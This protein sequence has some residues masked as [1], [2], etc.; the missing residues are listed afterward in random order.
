MHEIHSIAQ[1]LRFGHACAVQHGSIAGAE[2]ATLVDALL[3]VVVEIQM[4]LA[5]VQI[6]YDDIMSAFS[7]Q[8]AALVSDKMQT[9]YGQLIDLCF[10]YYDS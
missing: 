9:S 10:L 2:I 8:R 6:G 4:A 3:D 1:R 7:A 5:H